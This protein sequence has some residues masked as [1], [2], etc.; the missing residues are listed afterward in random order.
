MLFDRFN[1]ESMIGDLPDESE[2]RDCKQCGESFALD[3]HSG[4]E[5]EFC[6]DE[7]TMV[8]SGVAIETEND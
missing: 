4:F 3:C 6:S 8:Y 7:C 2:R 5:E 1:D